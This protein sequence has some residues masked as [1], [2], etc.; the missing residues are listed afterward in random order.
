MFKGLY[1]ALITPF[2]QGEIDAEAFCRLIEFQIA[3][4]VNGLVVCGTTG[5]SAVM[6]AEEY[7][8]TIELCLQTAAGRVPVIVGTGGNNTARVI[9]NT[10][11]A[12][13]MGADAALIVTPYYNKPMQQG[14]FEHYRTVHEACSLPIILYNVPGRTGVNL[15][16]ETIAQLAQLPRIVGIK[17]AVPDIMRPLKI[18]TA[19]EKQDFAVLSGED[20]SIIA[21]LA[22]GGDGCISVSANIAPALCAGLHRAWQD[23][24]WAEVERLRDLLWP[25][26]EVMFIETNPSPVKYAASL[27][28]YGD[29]TVRLPLCTLSE[30]SKE[31]VQAV[32]HSV[33]IMG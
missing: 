14:L 32:L 5:E 13:K 23:K 26:H 2:N 29:G 4:G 27:L 1:T 17:D 20:A 33:G 18:R 30:H 21:F 8:R 28:G 10:Q 3:A 19:V 24:N 7:G 9:E 25:L 16:V 11:L 12:Q 31:A 6:T 15:S 22:H